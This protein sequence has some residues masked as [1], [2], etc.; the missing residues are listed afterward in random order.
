MKSNF[1]KKILWMN[2]KEHSH[3]DKEKLYTFLNRFEFF[4]SLSHRQLKEIEPLFFRR[5]YEKDE[6][7]FEHNQ[8]G[9]ALFLIEIGDVSIEIPSGSDQF[10]QVA[11]LKP[12]SF[13]GELALLDNTPRSANARA[14]S[15][16]AAYALFR[17]D[18]NK[19]A[20]SHPE[21]A[22]HIFKGL[23]Q[24]IGERLKRTNELIHDQN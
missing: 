5:E 16:V 13:L 15:G 20:E 1:A 12:G 24:V 3:A 23:S 8:P 7:L 4:K 22:V 9:A 17:N 10:S 21:I 6:F 18:L 11:I 19:L 14:V 2:L